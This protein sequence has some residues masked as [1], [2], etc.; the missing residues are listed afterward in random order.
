MGRFN[1]KIEFQAPYSVEMEKE[2]VAAYRMYI[3]VLVREKEE[4]RRRWLE[5]QFT[6]VDKNTLVRNDQLGRR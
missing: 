5:T 6:R 2:Q 4:E 1:Y 3:E